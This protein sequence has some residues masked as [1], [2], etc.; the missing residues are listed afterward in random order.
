MQRLAASDSSEGKLHPS[1][2]SKGAVP[3]RIKSP[4]NPHDRSSQSK[5][6]VFSENLKVVESYSGMNKHCALTSLLQIIKEGYLLKAKI[7]DEGKKLR[8]NW[9]SSWIVLTGRKIEFYKEPKQPAVPN[10]VSSYLSHVS[11]FP[12]CF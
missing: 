3:M 11:S 2:E 12:K 1:H 10:L 4:S 8:K 7:A 9:T 5:S 6:M